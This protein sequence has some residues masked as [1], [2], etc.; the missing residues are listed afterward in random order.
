M[1]AMAKERWPA[2]EEKAK[3][4]KILSACLEAPRGG[5]QA[6]I[7]R[8]NHNSEMRQ[9]TFIVAPYHYRHRPVGA[10]GVIGPTRMEYDR[11]IRTV[12][13]VAEVTSRLLSANQSLHSL[14]ILAGWNGANFYLSH[15]GTKSD[16][17]NQKKN[18]R[19][20]RRLRSSQK[21]ELR[22][23]L[24]RKQAPRCLRIFPP[25]IRS[26]WP[27]SR[28]FTIGCCV[29]RQSLKISASGCRGKKRSSCS[30]LTST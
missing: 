14:P 15:W 28:S 20:H 12:E 22:S 30:T 27:K 1:V 13:Y 6:L 10:L 24:N 11:A 4:V 2:I 7:G 23:L 19:N 8:E 5:V 25:L 17:W 29:N 16:L 3:V 18:L 21:P 26:C 9:C